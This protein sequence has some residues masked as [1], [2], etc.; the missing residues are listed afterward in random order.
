MLK[1]LN[2]LGKSSN[3]RSLIIIDGINES[4]KKAWKKYL[5]VIVITIK[6]YPNVGLILSCR[7]PF[8]RQIF[9]KT[10]RGSFIA[11]FHKGFQ[12]IEL[13]AQ[14]EFFKYYKIP[15]PHFPLLTPE[16]SRP[17]F[18][19][20]LCLTFSGKTKSTKSRWI[21]EIASGQKSMTKLFE[22]FVNHI[23]SS[24][25][26]EFKL[27]K[28][29][30]W[31]ILKGYKTTAGMTV[32]FAATMANQAKD[33]V[34]PNECLSI[35]KEATGKSNSKTRLILNR[36]ISEGL[37]SEDVIWHEEVYY[38]VIRF[39]YQRFSD[40]LIARY[41]LSKYLNT[42]TEQSIRYSFYKHRPLGKI[43]EIINNGISYKM[44]GLASAIM[45]EFPERVK[46]SLPI[47][48]RELVYY[49][50]KK[51]RLLA[52]LV[53]IFLEGVLWRNKDSFSSQ[54]AKLFGI[55]LTRGSARVQRDVLETCVILAS[56][57]GHPYSAERLY[58][59]LSEMKIDERDLLWSEYLR[60][61]YS[62]SVVHRLLN[63]VEDTSTSEIDYETARNLILL[64]ALF[65]TT[66]SRVLR[67]KAT[68][69]LVLV[70][71]RQPKALF[72]KT[73]ISLN[74]KD[75]YV[76]ERMLAACYG[77]LMR[78]W[79]FPKSNLKS[80]ISDFAKD[81]YDAMFGVKAP[82]S[83]THILS[84]DYA[85]GC[86]E[87]AKRIQRNCL[88]KR[89]LKCLR[90]PFQIPRVKI[91]KANK[92]SEKYCK[93]ADSAIYMDFENYTIGG[94]VS[95]R[96]NYDS[97]H[98]VYRGVVRQIKWRILDLGYSTEL[99]QDIDRSI[100]QGNFYREQNNHSKID[101]Y[102]KKYSWIAF[103]EVA[104]I[105]ADQG[106]LSEYHPGRISDCDIDPSF[107]ENL[108]LWQPRL[109]KFFTDRYKSA[110]DWILSGKSPSYDHLL[111]LPQ[112]DGLE[113]PWVSLE[114]FISESA[115]ND[116]RRI[117]TFIDGVFVKPNDIPKLRSKFNS[118][119]Y[120]GN[121]AI[122]QPSGDYYTF[123]GEIP[124][125]K[126]YGLD[127]YK[128]TKSKRHIVQCFEGH[129]TFFK[130]KRYSDL[131]FVEIL[132]LESKPVNIIFKNSEQII[133]DEESKPQPKYV[134]VPQY[135]TIPG[136]NVE[137]P[138]HRLLWESYH[139][140]ENEGGGADYVAPALCDFLNLRNKNNNQD[141]FDK[142]G[143]QAS[144]YR[145]FGDE[146]KYFK[147]NLFYIRKDLLKKYL[148]HT[149]QKLV[150]FIW[151]ER[152]FKHEIFD[153][154]RSQVNDLR[155]SHIHIH[156][157]MKVAKLT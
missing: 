123:A 80:C 150:W 31:Q 96:H 152:E 17:L 29:K 28:K 90:K 118:L 32:G 51:L 147:S 72:E 151:G 91:P 2:A 70:G 52:P 93:K 15:N 82:H 139:S 92:I 130:R 79:A 88:G 145:L 34:E 37:L 78:S 141:L 19:K 36:L 59:Y 102:G 26:S 146:S 95:D 140:T 49:L 105:R 45:L 133:V 113:G 77:V 155:S 39:P 42:S 84:R 94:L 117:F 10:S 136:I 63:W 73:I 20:I 110:R 115:I 18:L 12:E 120:P 23:G 71:E 124:W 134:K 148:K 14:R 131:T 38:N 87:L 47:D 9:T 22:D 108:R 100:S 21:K 99:F 86:I 69:S 103:F 35:I 46:N 54:T 62:D 53:D 156:K 3:C 157:K 4:D 104:G 112:V 138:I 61:T 74:F 125:S 121:F 33:Y 89:S 60:N 135:K 119:K 6:K 75:P 143:Q 153:S 132:G 11:I 81:L 41:L 7:T 129:K 40:H 97:K 144:V 65:L 68:K 149:H 55:L 154:I 5:A 16:F 48:E 107:P 116:P 83:T 27:P 8:D 109:N 126:K 137:V 85:L 66:T 128:D 13:D 44:P 106:L 57:T 25:E 76:S 50:P 56:R 1:E 114:G 127:Y 43:F 64:I 142:S 24:I 101:R 111:Q 122:P 98:K 67:D 58:I 30:C